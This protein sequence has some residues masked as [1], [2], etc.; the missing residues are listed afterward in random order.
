MKPF[1]EQVATVFESSRKLLVSHLRNR[2]HLRHADAED[3][4]QEVF[5]KMLRYPH[6]FKGEV[7]RQGMY[8]FAR[9]VVINFIRDREASPEACE[10]EL[11]KA[12]HVSVRGVSSA[13]M[14]L[15]RIA[16][17]MRPREWTLLTDFEALGYTYKELAQRNGQSESAI[18]NR[19]YRVHHK[20]Q[21]IMQAAI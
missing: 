20:A 18:K 7:T 4:A 9:F 14:E 1:E 6:Y 3:L 13:S 15:Q 21:R 10:V 16:A 8:W 17:K 19:L 11:D 12:L 5:V 2:W